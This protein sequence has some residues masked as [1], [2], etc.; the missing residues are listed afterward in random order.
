MCEQK[1]QLQVIK[2]QLFTPSTIQLF[3]DN[4]PAAS[5]ELAEKAASRF[6]KMV[7]TTIVQNPT[8][9]KCSFASIAKA[10]SQSASLDLDIDVRGLAYLVPYR[11]KVRGLEAQF[12]IG[13]LGLIELAYRS[14]KV[15][16]ISAHCIYESEK[17]KV[18]IKRIDG[19][20]S[21]KHP[22][23]FEKP[24]GKMIAV[25]ATAEIEGVAP[26]T[27]V[28]RS[29]EVEEFRKLSKAPNSPAWKDHFEAMAKK[30]A[31]RQLAKFLPKSILEDFAR[32]AA[33]D[34]RETFV[35]AQVSAE[36]Q[37]KNE[38]GSEVMDTVF[39]DEADPEFEAK[40][41]A[42]IDKL[43]NAENKEPAFMQDN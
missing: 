7:Y 31:I 37:I 20:F 11:D 8:L 18:E 14:G 13:Y 1:N 10:A 38:A 22:F 39:E 32:G 42:A 43:K 5:K 33:I 29:E 23:S 25:Y 41:Q 6:A 35:E 21:V 16:A 4:L 34:E 27:V 9:Q 30:T 17:D 2:T 15:K 36:E 28:L 19:Q 12:Q 24:S 3:K 26:Q 40:K